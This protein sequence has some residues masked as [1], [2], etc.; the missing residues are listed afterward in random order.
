MGMEPS[1][2]PS[3]V[4]VIGQSAQVRQDLSMRAAEAGYEVV[5]ALAPGEGLP[6]T[7]TA[8]VD[9]ILCQVGEEEGQWRSF[10]ERV[11]ED[12]NHACILV[13]GPNLPA[14]QV[15]ALLRA[16]AFDYLTLPVRASRMTQALEEGLAVRRS[17]IQVQQLSSTLQQVNRELQSD[18]DR[19]QQWNRNLRL[20]NQL[21]QT[22]S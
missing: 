20:L 12:H 18:R 14:E 22:I 13:V 10:V 2:M 3:T 4:L 1:T 11:R 5:A 9:A 19:L 7:G 17:F 16:G 15:A 21:G 8:P 6:G